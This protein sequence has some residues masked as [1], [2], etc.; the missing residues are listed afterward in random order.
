MEV[1]TIDSVT[2]T[3][4]DHG[5]FFPLTT[6]IMG[7]TMLVFGTVILVTSIYFGIAVLLLGIFISFSF[8]GIEIDTTKKEVNE[9]NKYLGFI[10]T[11]KK[12]SYLKLHYITAMP[13]RISKVGHANLVQNTVDTEYKFS[14]TLF[15]ENL[16]T[17][18]EIH[19][20]TSKSKA[21][22]VSKQLSSLLELEYFEYDPQFI[23]DR[24]SQR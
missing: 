10:K 2:P 13:K 19:T 9:Y 24:I 12:Y 7:Y 6:R 14:I 8:S 11:T 4:F 17:K 1:Q 3:K 21:V 20:Y 15:T 5:W 22:F 18:K 16:R 23:R